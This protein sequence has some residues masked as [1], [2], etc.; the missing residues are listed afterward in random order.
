MELVVERGGNVAPLLAGLGLLVAVLLGSWWT[1]NA[2]A[3][4]RVA[5][6]LLRFTLSVFGGL[7]YVIMLRIATGRG[8]F[9]R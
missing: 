4:G 3:E 7:Y 1:G 8:L 9:P 5:V 6:M 2:V